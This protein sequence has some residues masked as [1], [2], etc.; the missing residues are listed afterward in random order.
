MIEKENL[1]LDSSKGLLPTKCA[2][3]LKTEGERTPVQCQHLNDVFLEICDECHERF[4]KSGNYEFELWQQ[5]IETSRE[6]K[7]KQEAKE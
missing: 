2:S 1:I 5:I 6:W 4:S 7:A 3:C